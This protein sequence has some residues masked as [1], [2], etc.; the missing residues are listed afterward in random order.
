MKRI[1][2]TVLVFA[3]IILIA[4]ALSA[5]KPQSRQADHQY[6]TTDEFLLQIIAKNN[7]I[8]RLNKEILGELKESNRLFRS[9][10]G[11]SGNSVR[12]YRY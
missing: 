9:V 10:I 12:T 7:E 4:F 2:A 3:M 8:V 11:A 6:T 1:E 5:F